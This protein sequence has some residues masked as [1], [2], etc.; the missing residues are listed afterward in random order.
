MSLTSL[1][2]VRVHENITSGTT[3]DSILQSLIVAVSSAMVSWIGQEIE[4]TTVT[5]EKIDSIGQV[6]IFTRH[7]PIVS[8]TTLKENGTT[9]TE[10]THFECLGNDKPIGRIVRTG[11]GLPIAWASG[12]RVISVTYKYGYKSVP[13]DLELACIKQVRHE[14]AQTKA[15]GANRLGV[16]GK[17]L[18]TGGT[19][20]YERDGF[21]PSV[22]QVMARYRVGI[23]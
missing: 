20:S 14:F 19:L 12:S 7:R 9:L 10:N 2:A 8:I 21:L 11:G 6:A 22:L 3:H 17:A 16:T 4:E 18:D 1:E 23:F 15:S 13:Q 5:T